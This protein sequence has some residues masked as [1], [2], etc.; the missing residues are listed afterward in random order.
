MPK[1][2]SVTGYGWSGSGLLV[3]VLKKQP[4]N[5]TIENEFSLISE[6]DGLIDLAGYFGDNWHF[7]KTGVA[8]DRFNAFAKR[9]VAA[10]SILNPGGLSLN[11]SLG[12]NAEG[13]LEEFID[14]LIGFKYKSRT[15]V[16]FTLGNDFEK[17]VRKLKWKIA[18]TNK[19][20]HYFSNLDFDDFARNTAEFLGS[21]LFHD[22]LNTILDQAI[23]ATNFKVASRL[24][25]SSTDYFIVDRDPR[26]VFAE[27][28]L[29]GGLIGAE[30]KGAGLKETDKFIKWYKTIRN[31][32][33]HLGIATYVRFENLVLGKDG[34]R[35]K[36]NDVLGKDIFKEYSMNK[37]LQNVGKWRT[38][39]LK[40]IDRI[41]QNIDYPY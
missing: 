9:T 14:R 35:D 36:V 13:R 41:M 21:L 28:M 12:V 27:L 8:I 19:A 29:T 34:D 4:E 6:P 3:D 40:L 39:D 30:L 33:D 23:P 20:T 24:L 38:I 15:R 25:P 16:N 32:S 2:L 7:I 22:Q 31:R 10:K 11:D 37:S 17:T 1:I 26:D 18:G 5:R